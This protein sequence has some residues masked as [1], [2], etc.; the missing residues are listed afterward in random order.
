LSFLQK[1]IKVMD[2]FTLPDLTYDYSALAPVIDEETMHL[3][4]DKHH[5]TYVKNLNDALA[6]HPE[7]LDKDVTVL[8]RELS[9]VPE[10][11]R[12]KVRNNGG[13]HANHSFFWQIMRAPQDDNRP[14]GDVMDAISQHFGSFEEFQAKFAE[15]ATGQFGSGWAWLVLVD[16]K[17]EVSNTPNQDNPWMEGKTPILGLDVWEHA[18]YLTYQNRRPEYI[19]NFWKVVNWDKVEEIF[20][21][22]K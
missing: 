7:F 11:V 12:T 10:E 9:T 2:M 5:A 21:S 22:N 15:K 14:T 20:K 1:D 3:H 16:G 13:G 8:M 19:E 6:Q 18:Y 17:L 4:H